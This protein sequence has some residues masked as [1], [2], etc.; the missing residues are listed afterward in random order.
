MTT[1]KALEEIDAVLEQYFRGQLSPYE[2]IN[3]IARIKGSVEGQQQ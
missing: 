3:Q 2:T 1:Q